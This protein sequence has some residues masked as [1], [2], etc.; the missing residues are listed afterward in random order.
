MR[1]L[2]LY[3]LGHVLALTALVALALVGIQSFLAFVAELDD[4]GQGQFGYLA[5]FTYTALLIPRGFYLMLPVIGMLGTLL[6]LGVL[7]SQSELTAMRASGISVLRIGGSTLMA[8][9]VLAVLC[10][11]LGDW[12]APEG[13]LR[14]ESLRTEARL[15]AASGAIDRP[16]W[17][18]E[19]N[20]IV[21]LRQLRS[22]NHLGAAEIFTLDESHRLRAVTSI[23]EAEFSENRWRLKNARRTDFAGQSTQAQTLPEQDWEGE[24]A[25]DVLRL[26][27]LET[28]ALSMRGLW[29]LIGYMDDNRLDASAYRLAFW[30]KA[31]APLTVIA[32]MLFAVP[33]V[34]GPLRSAGA[35]QRL[36]LGILIGLSFYVIND[37]V[38][39]TGQLYGWQPWISAGAPTAALFATAFWRLQR[40]S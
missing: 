24:L 23:D 15:G 18:R 12:L 26:F 22:E 39:N 37:I 34:F 1:R 13:Q 4:V 17:L 27:V 14:A 7:A 38:A 16:L 3:I 33:F 2:D 6:G 30:R 32:L 28:R 10:L 5:L 40:V 29:R 11:L 25:P 19:G 35:G 9:L 8:G 21:H 31:V 36:L 20:H